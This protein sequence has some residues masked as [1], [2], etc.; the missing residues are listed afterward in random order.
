MEYIDF[1]GRVHQSTQRD[2]VGRVTSADKAECAK[3]AKKF[4]YD[5]FDGDRNY[6]YGGYSYDGRWKAV[7]E[8]MI[9]HYSLESGM[10]ILDIGC[11]KAH[12]LLEIKR[13]IPGIEVCG[14]DISEYAITHT[15]TDIMGSL[16]QGEAQDLSRYDDNS[17]DF[18]FSINAL[19][20][21]KIYDLRKAIHEINRVTKGKSYIVVESWRTE[22]ERVNMLYW[23]L[24]CASFY[25]V[26]EWEW[27]YKEFGYKGDYGFIFFE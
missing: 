8:Q 11:G 2:Y 15:E 23:Q 4:G 22:E 17:F 9:E 21:L 5:F 25:D 18:V 1:I 10:R 20:N 27:L 6:G 7:A 24:T 16:E 13:L 3:V 14:I 26:G 12:L 19:H